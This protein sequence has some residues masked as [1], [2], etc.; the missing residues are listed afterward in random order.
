MGW[1][2]DDDP[3]DSPVYAMCPECEDRNQIDDHGA[4]D[5][6]ETVTCGTCGHTFTAKDGGIAFWRDFD[7]DDYGDQ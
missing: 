5:P 7:H 6:N 3:D 2:Y 1:P 4:Y